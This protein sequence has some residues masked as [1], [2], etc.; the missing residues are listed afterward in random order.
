MTTA[1]KNGRTVQNSTIGKGAFA[2]R[3]T[4][5]HPIIQEA[6]RKKPTTDIIERLQEADKIKVRGMGN[7][8]THVEITVPMA[9]D[10]L[11]YNERNR[12]VHFR[13]IETYTGLQI[14]NAWPFIGDVLRFSNKFK[15][16]DGQHR[17][18]AQ[19]QANKKVVYH[20]QLGLDEKTFKSM[21][22][23]RKRSAGDMMAVAG[24]DDWNIL[25]AAAKSVIMFEKEHLVYT[26]T[27]DSRVGIEETYQWQADEQQIKTLKSCLKFVKDEIMKAPGK[28]YFSR[29]NWVFIYYILR[30]KHPTSA[31]EFLSQLAKGENLS[32]QK[33]PSV[34]MLKNHLDEI[35]DGKEFIK[36]YMLYTV[37]MK[38]LI[39]AWNN[40]IDGVRE[41]KLKINK[42]VLELDKIH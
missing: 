5:S 28:K 19:I 24:H 9:W 38:Y 37:K 14:D 34:Y 11:H 30:K 15:L 6:L 39:K 12:P 13:S 17:L 42:E 26:K 23:G 20:I 25:A 22:L 32:M 2:P 4:T 21:D 33:T 35:A 10:I 8:L 36:G 1:V 16:L 29:A 18:I 31:K 3:S 27:R 7:I 40:Y 41:P